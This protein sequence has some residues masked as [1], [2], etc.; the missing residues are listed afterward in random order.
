MVID[1]TAQL[2]WILWGIDLAMIVAGLAI[3]ASVMHRELGL[4]RSEE[5]KRKFWLSRGE[6]APYPVRG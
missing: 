1:M 5:R 3:L 4:R 2:S 6:T